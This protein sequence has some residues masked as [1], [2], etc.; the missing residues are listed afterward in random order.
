MWKRIIKNSLAIAGII[1]IFY[2]LYHFISGNYIQ[3][4]LE[5][6]FVCPE[7]SRTYVFANES[8]KTGNESGKYRIRANKI[9]FIE[10][11]TE[12]FIRVHRDYIMLDGQH[13]LRR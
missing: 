3:D 5:G 13:F 12:Y 8:Y 9:I 10:V 6:E 4:R 1:I 11:G 2:L 7:T